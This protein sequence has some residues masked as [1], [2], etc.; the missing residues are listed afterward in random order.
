MDG[1]HLYEDNHCVDKVD[2][3][4]FFPLLVRRVARAPSI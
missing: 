1:Y 2:R 4:I 3:V